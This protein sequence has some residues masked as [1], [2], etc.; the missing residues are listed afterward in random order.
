MEMAGKIILYIIM[1]SAVAGCVASVVNE[2]SELGKKFVEGIYA[3]GPIFLP[4]AGI[5]ALIPILSKLIIAVFA[6][7]YEAL[8][9]DLAM[10]ATT[11]IAVD[12]G[13][14]QLAHSLAQ[15][16]ESWLMAAITGYMAGATIVF[17]V[18]IGLKI[19]DNADRKYMALGIMAGMLAIPFGVIGAALCLFFNPV[20]V[21]SVISIDA[22]Y[23]YVVNFTL[24]LIFYNSLP[25]IVICLAIAW[26]LW[27]KPDLMINGFN[28]FGTTMEKILKVVLLLC[29]IEMAT[30]FFSST[31]NWWPFDPII[32][33]EADMNRALEVSGYIGLMLAGAFPMVYMLQKGLNK[34]LASIAEKYGFDIEILGG[35]LAAAANILALFAMVKDMKPR[36]KVICIAFGVCCAFLFGDHLAFTAN[37][38][39]SLIFYVMLGKAIGGAAAVYFASIIVRRELRGE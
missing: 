31:F 21:R 13:G 25:L 22:P 24:P 26:G 36:A 27:K 23:D 35:I 16:K 12:M 18:P 10:V 11:F 3:I 9:A 14:Y 32:A 28:I 29:I 2:E 17:S 1:L 4:V 34:I 30:G 19:I 37:F 38:Q 33:D 15:T 7:I 8:G 20:A 39:P 5:M 6:P